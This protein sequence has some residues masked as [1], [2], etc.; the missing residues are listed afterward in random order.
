MLEE[1]LRDFEHLVA[2]ITACARLFYV[3]RQ[4]RKYM[5]V[6]LN[7]GSNPGI[8]VAL[9][10]D[11]L[12]EQMK[13]EAQIK[14]KNL[15]EKMLFAHK[16]PVLKGVVDKKYDRVVCGLNTLSQKYQN[17]FQEPK[18]DGDYILL[19]FE[20]LHCYKAYHEAGPVKALLD[21][22]SYDA[23]RN[24]TYKQA[25]EALRKAQNWENADEKKKTDSGSIAGARPRYI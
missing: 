9:L 14:G 11:R 7:T 25:E 4:I 6:N 20:E 21:D 22:R 3:S 16:D 5:D 18:D 19:R 15:K 24:E 23:K 2:K 13:A 17:Y 8:E 12:Y 10:D 1:Q